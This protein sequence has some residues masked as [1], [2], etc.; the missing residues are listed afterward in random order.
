MN[1]TKGSNQAL[2]ACAPVTGDDGVFEDVVRD[3][4]AEGVGRIEDVAVLRVQ[5][6]LPQR[7]APAVALPRAVPCACMLAAL[8]QEC[9]HINAAGYVHPLLM[10]GSLAQVLLLSVTCAFGS[11]LWHLTPY[12]QPMHAPVMA[13]ASYPSC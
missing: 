1:E 8:P 4:A 10:L 6:Q 2:R 12:R 7:L 5:R 3:G 13:A 9:P 11:M